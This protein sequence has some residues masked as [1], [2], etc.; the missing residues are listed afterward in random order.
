MP[1][2]KKLQLSNHRDQARRELSLCYDCDNTVT[3]RVRCPTCLQKRVKSNKTLRTKRT[4]Q[5]M[6]RYC[7]TTHSLPDNRLCADC[8]F[9]K[10]AGCI[11]GTKIEWQEIRDK[12]HA[13]N[14][15]CP[16]SGIALTLGLNAEL[17]HIIPSSRGGG[18]NI[19][20]LQWVLTRVNR[21]KHQMIESEFFELI[22]TLYH[23][24]KAC[25]S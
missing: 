12:F 10:R 4:A 20:N 24:K 6:C 3:D 9:K 25:S 16:L 23:F 19:E 15:K 11:R 22:E 18:D 8:Y 1:F 5:G 2:I 7:M 17:D 21:M 13:Q 14:G